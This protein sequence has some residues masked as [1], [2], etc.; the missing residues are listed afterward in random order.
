MATAS[1]SSL[2]RALSSATDRSLITAASDI[3]SVQATMRNSWIAS[4]LPAGD[5]ETNGPCP[6]PAPQMAMN[7][8]VSIA[9]A[10]APGAET[11]CGADEQRQRR[12]EQRRQGAGPRLMPGEDRPAHGGQSDEDAGRLE[13]AA[14]RH[15]A[16]VVD[17]LDRGQD[18]R[19][20]RDGRD[21]V[22][23]HASPPDRPVVG[24]APPVEHDEPGVEE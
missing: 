12:I 21:H 19:D 14:Q 7:A 3:T 22:R 18:D 16:V 8:Q 15:P 23:E 6:C 24:A 9:R 17:P 13:T 1:C 20:Q 10:R 5:W 4:A 2:R 11:Q